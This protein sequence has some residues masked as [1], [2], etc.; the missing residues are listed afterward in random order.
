M[1]K[2]KTMEKAKE[3]ILIHQVAKINEFLQ[4]LD[5]NFDVENEIPDEYSYL[6]IVKQQ[7]EAFADR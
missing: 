5:A 4:V 6:S 7:L 1:D 3:E 2:K